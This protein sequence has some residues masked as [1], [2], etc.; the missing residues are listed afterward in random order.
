MRR[1][2]KK[3][4]ENHTARFQCQFPIFFT[5]ISFCL[6]APFPFTVFTEDGRYLDTRL[7]IPSAVC[8]SKAVVDPGG[9]QKKVWSSRGEHIVEATARYLTSR[10][11]KI[12]KGQTRPIR[13]MA[14]PPHCL[15]YEFSLDTFK[16]TNHIVARPSRIGASL[17]TNEK[18]WE[19]G[20]GRATTA[21][22]TQSQDCRRRASRM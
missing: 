8:R 18:G 17:S 20:G 2:R 6:I 11:D 3:N 9:R 13:T 5:P 22:D 7:S 10:P 4:L 14:L 21:S 16:I 15:A 12:F 1:R 19:N